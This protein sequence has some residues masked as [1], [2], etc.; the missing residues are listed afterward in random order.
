MTAEIAA[1]PVAS[2]RKAI[3][4]LDAGTRP[5]YCSGVA[6][7]GLFPQSYMGE[8]KPD[9]QEL[10]F[11]FEI[12]GE[13]WENDEGDVFPRTLSKR[14]KYV[15]GERANYTKLAAALDPDG[16]KGSPDKFVGTFC[17]LDVK[18]DPRKDQNGGFVEGEFTNKIAGVVGA[19]NM[20]GYQPPE[21][22]SEGFV[23]NFYAPTYED[24][25]KLPR[26]TQ[27]VV[28]ENLDFEGSELQ[29]LLLE[30]ETADGETVSGSM[31]HNV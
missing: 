23:F 1:P 15:G 29:K 22:L 8:T 31:P 5:A 9:K 18:K 25:S 13:T 10:I 2:E 7:I 21:Q 30:N 20:P 11:F 14:I 3:P 19:P 12:A 26:W 4:A 24:Y 16:S 6:L 17:Q 27:K 28:K